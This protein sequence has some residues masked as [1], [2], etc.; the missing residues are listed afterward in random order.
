MKLSSTFRRASA[1]ALASN[2]A[3]LLLAGVPLL[4][5][6]L[7]ATAGLLAWSRGLLGCC[8]LLLLPSLLDEG[9]GIAFL[10]LFVAPLLLSLLLRAFLLPLLLSALP[11]SELDSRFLALLLWAAGL[12]PRFGCTK[13]RMRAPPVLVL[14][15][16]LL[17]S[18]PL[19]PLPSPLASS[20]LPSLSLPLPSPSSS[21]E[22]PFPSASALPLLSALTIAR[23]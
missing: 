15:L 20:P 5:S 2:C 9:R 10:F 12:L 13:P 18:S 11:S 16:V 4:P 22:E 6:A 1:V 23:I 19:S 21:P 8:T 7:L 14:L 17:R 3:L